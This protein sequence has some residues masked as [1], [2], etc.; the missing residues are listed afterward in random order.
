M[1]LDGN[2]LIVIGI[3]VLGWIAKGVGTSYFGKKGE[4]LA[5]KEDIQEIT[6]KIETV[7][8]MFVSRLHIQHVRYEHEFKILLELSERLV[9][10]RDATMGLRPETSYGDVNDPKERETRA[11]SYKEAALQLYSFVESRQPFFSEDIYA[12]LKALEQKSWTEFV[13]FKHQDPNSQKFWADAAA[14]ASTI[15]SMASASLLLIR[16]RARSW[17]RFDAV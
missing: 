14:N 3:F 9:A 10:L 8:A 16:Q 1:R 6:N 15:I 2:V 7:K 12:S 17:E 11:S 4:N 5:T 13:Q